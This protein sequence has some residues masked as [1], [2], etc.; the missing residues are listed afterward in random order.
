MSYRKQ[1]LQNKKIR[2]DNLRL[3][4]KNSNTISDAI[5]DVDFGI[6][7]NIQDNR[8]RN[9]ILNDRFLTQETAMKNANKL[10]DN[11][12]PTSQNL[13]N[14]IGE[15]NYL[16]FN[17]YFI[18]I[19]TAL[20]S[21]KAYLTVDTAYDFISNYLEKQDYNSGIRD[22]IPTES[23]LN[24]LIDK[25][26]QQGN[27]NRLTKEDL[28]DKITALNVTLLKNK[29]VN[30]IMYDKLQ[31][32]TA[33]KVNE[34][35]ETEDEDDFE[36]EINNVTGSIT[37]ESIQ[38]IDEEDA[39]VIVN[40]TMDDMV[41]NVEQ[42]N[43]EIPEISAE[44]KAYNDYVDYILTPEV[45]DIMRNVLEEPYYLRKNTSA[46][47]A[48][49]F[50][51]DVEAIRNSTFYS[52]K[53]DPDKKAKKSDITIINRILNIADGGGTV[54]VILNKTLRK[55]FEDLD[56][57]KIILILKT[58]EAEKRAE[59]KGSAPEI[60]KSAR[61]ATMNDIREPENEDEGAQ[62]KT[63]TGSGIRSRRKIYKF[64]R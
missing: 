36:N 29:N 35:I 1:Q 34:L 43:P 28:I 6:I 27:I 57:D 30:K 50:E 63:R 49:Q 14:R 25:I 47:P 13:L 64:R 8:T 9:E 42:D 33:E 41:K 22:I 39:E 4:I 5:R 54:S 61:M 38:E 53:T 60:R 31:L 2:E 59:A 40:E 51:R 48:E 58:D 24:S 16:T 17:R 62:A 10:F 18:N 32:L 23:L 52:I 3:K 20:E 12:I 11:D 19:Y 56:L 21:Q 15:S 7:P 45:Q 26:E 46:T 37:A 44:D 55:K